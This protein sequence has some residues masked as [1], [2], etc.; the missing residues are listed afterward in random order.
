MNDIAVRISDAIGKIIPFVNNTPEKLRGRF[1]KLACRRIS[2]TFLVELYVEYRRRPRRASTCT[3]MRRSAFEL[4][5]FFA[6]FA[7]RNASA[8]LKRLAPGAKPTE[9][10]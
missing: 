2:R 8:S 5:R 6:N 3:L 10:A 9:G 7:K 1:R 4:R